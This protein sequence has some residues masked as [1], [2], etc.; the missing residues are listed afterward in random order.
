MDYGPL[1]IE[2]IEAGEELIREFDKF[3]PVKAAV[4]L[5]EM[6]AGLRSLY[7]ASDQIDGTTLGQGYGEILRIADAMNTPYLNP[8]R[9][10]L[11]GGD[12]PLAQAV[13]SLH[14]R[15]PGAPAIRLGETFFGNLNTED[16]YIYPTPIPAEVS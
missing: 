9:V 5:K 8:F 11:I 13:S 10:K 3:M 1:V 15:Y 2:E 12:H 7:I 14:Q 4:W 16:V 6:D